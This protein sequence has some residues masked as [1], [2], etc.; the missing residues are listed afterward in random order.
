M[1]LRKNRHG[2]NEGWNSTFD[3][4]AVPLG[5]DDDGDAIESAFVVP[6]Q[7]GDNDNGEQLSSPGARRFTEAMEAVLQIESVELL[8]EGDDTPVAGARLSYV[9][10]D[11]VA[12]KGGQVESAERAFRRARSSAEAGNL[13]AFV[14]QG[15][16]EYVYRVT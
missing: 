15:G 6:F 16:I 13:V 12:R 11:Y 5:T 1:L 2:G 14:E 10:A 8:R 3:L 9:Q 7:P 4:R